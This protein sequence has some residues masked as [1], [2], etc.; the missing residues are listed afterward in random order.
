MFLLF[1][2]GVMN[3]LW[4]AGLA[5]LVLLEKFPAQGRFLSRAT[6]AVLIAGGL[7]LIYRGGMG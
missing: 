4:V 6:G 1:V 3:L 2:G 5:V 7:L